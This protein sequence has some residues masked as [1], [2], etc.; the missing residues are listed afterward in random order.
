MTLANISNRIY[1]LICYNEVGDSMVLTTIDV[2]SEYAKRELEEQRE[3]LLYERRAKGSYE[4]CD[5]VVVRATDYLGEDRTIKPLF[6]V[7]FVTKNNHVIKS[8]VEDILDEQEHIDFFMDMD[9]Y[10]ER[11]AMIKSN[12]LPY[13]SQYRS[14]VHFSINGLVASH[15][16]GDF[17][18]RNFI[19]IDSFQHHLQ[20]NDIRS[21]RMEDTYMYGDVTLSPQAVIMIKKEKYEELIL[22][23]PQLNQYNVVLYVGDEKLAVESYLQSIGII[24]EKIGEHGS[25]EHRCTPQINEFRRKLK[26]GY[27]IDAE[28]HWLSKEYK[29]DDQNSLIVWDYYNNLFYSHLL[30]KLN[31]IEPEYSVRLSDLMN[32]GLDDQNKEY[33]KQ[34]IRKISLEQFKTIVDEFNMIILNSIA[35]GTF[36]NNDEVVTSLLNNQKV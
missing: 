6:H 17:S 36:K 21:F 3:D 18:N 4:V 16:K 8:A 23:Y 34:V 33:I 5:F 24:S 28:P 10:N 29:E 26:E 13:S 12:Y 11:S 35:N 32:M 27:G 15:A 25:E 14:T 1:Y 22:Q 7:P 20:N 19:I 2:T 31:V 30:T 9:R